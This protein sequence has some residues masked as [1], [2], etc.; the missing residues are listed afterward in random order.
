MIT[1][2]TPS[3]CRYTI[4]R[5]KQHVYLISAVNCTIHID[6][7]NAWVDNLTE[8]PLF[9][10][11]A[12][13]L[14][15]STSYDDRFKFTKSVSLTVQNYVNL[16]Y[17]QGKYYVILE[18]EGGNYWF[19]NPDFP[20][21]VTY[22][23]TL[24]DDVSETQFT[25]NSLSNFPLLGFTGSLTD[26]RE[27]EQYVINGLKR[28]RL[29][30]AKNAS[31]DQSTSTV[32]LYHDKEFY[33]VE[34]LDG[35]LSITEEFDGNQV[36]TSIQFS[37]QLDNYKPSWQYNLL[38]YQDNRYAAIITTKGAD[39]EF[40]S[41]FEFGLVPSY[42]IV[43]GDSQ[44]DIIT[45][46]L[47]GASSYGS[48]PSGGDS[49]QSVAMSRW[50]V[51]EKEPEY[52][53]K[54]TDEWVCQ[55]VE[56][57]WTESGTT[58]DNAN[59]YQNNIKEIS[60]DGGTTWS[61]VIP[62]E[63]SASTLVQQDSYDCGYRTGTTSSSTY[64]N[65]DDLYVDVYYRTSRDSGTTW[66]TASTTPTLV[67]VGGC[68]TPP[69]PS[70]EYLTLVAQG[71]GSF[72]FR[73]EAST[74]DILCSK[75][76]GEWTLKSDVIVNNGDKVVWKGDLV[77][78]SSYGIGRFA[79]T[80]N[81]TVS[82]NPMSLLFGD[83]FSGQTSLAGY[84]NAFHGLFYNCTKLTSIDGLVLP[85][86]TLSEKC[87]TYMFN[88]CTGLTSIGNLVLPATTLADYCY[89]GMFQ[90]CPN[91]TTVPS[92]LLPATTLASH[93]YFDM[94]LYC[95]SLTTVPSNLLPATTLEYGC[96][97]NMFGG[98]TSLTTVPSNL[99]P[100]TTLADECYRGMFSRCSSLTSIPS[101]LLP[102]T[103]LA[104]GC[105]LNM[106]EYC[107]SLTT[108]PSNLLPA[109]TLANTCYE[110]MFQYCTSL[111]TAP[112]LPATTLTNAC[113]EYMFY[114]CSSLNYIKCLATDISADLATSNWTYGVGRGGT[115]VKAASVTDWPRGSH[116]IPSG[117]EVQNGT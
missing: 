78:N 65:G 103:I 60:T 6:N 38:E 112:K 70:G 28:L 1:T 19:V 48:L 66:T 17:L 75:N 115:F 30:E 27:C 98:C 46:T 107:T 51:V 73:Y 33:D 100:A 63:Y 11:G 23:Y 94:F 12:V 90:S 39:G 40:I 113:Y 104:N 2:Y 110:C 34:F 108:V 53:W 61:V 13:T 111:T 25:F 95:T 32:Y 114:G 45:I 59:K 105:Y 97:M 42:S 109:T 35:T 29:T 86:T 79:S 10:K 85:A 20:C 69:S 77:P 26:V 47:Q 54:L 117:W 62:E 4:D 76:G 67:E 55:P 8:T 93:C 71:S 14:N 74:G 50:T 92:N 106:F 43:G 22:T 83:N 82:G 80:C 24:G 44:D 36:N 72:V 101:G 37:I 21:L 88:Y 87:Y 31:Y 9:I 3:R 15:E 84:K 96:Y 58:C 64:C 49:E 5:L 81:F 41:G 102:T 18:D 68:P 116:G 52:T 57:R 91:L 16:S 89:Y 99:L 7:G 56:Y